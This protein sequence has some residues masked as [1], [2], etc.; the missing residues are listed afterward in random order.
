MVNKEDVIDEGDIYGN[1][2]W[3]LFTLLK[4]MEDFKVDG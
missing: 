1:I 2:W 3:E 4:K